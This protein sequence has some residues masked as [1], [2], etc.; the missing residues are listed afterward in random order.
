MLIKSKA[1]R[2]E[3]GKKKKKRA[4]S[5]KKLCFLSHSYKFEKIMKLKFLKST[6]L[7]MRCTRH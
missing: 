7:E 4:Y 1:L 3:T 5:I 6:C 2:R